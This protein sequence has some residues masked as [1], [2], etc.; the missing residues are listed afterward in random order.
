MVIGRQDA[1][2]SMKRIPIQIVVVPETEETLGVLY[3]LC[4]DGTIWSRVTGVHSTDWAQ[5]VDV[6]QDDE[7]K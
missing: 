6:P 5:I 2:C 3:A 4:N 1:H 7:E